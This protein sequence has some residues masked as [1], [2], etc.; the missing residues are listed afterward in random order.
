MAY[1]SSALP[2]YW[3]GN[4]LAFA[5]QEVDCLL[6]MTGNIAQKAKQLQIFY[7]TFAF[8]IKTKNVKNPTLKSPQKPLPI[9]VADVSHEVWDSLL[10]GLS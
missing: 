4:L 7:V 10:S 1:S 6:Q 9:A 5:F 8:Q 3:V 2:P